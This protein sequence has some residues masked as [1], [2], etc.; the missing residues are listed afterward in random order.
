MAE[1]FDDG[2]VLDELLGVRVGELDRTAPA[3][4]VLRRSDGGPDLGVDGVAAV[5]GQARDS[6]DVYV[7]EDTGLV[8]EEGLN[9]ARGV[10][11]GWGFVRESV[12]GISGDRR[13]HV[14]DD[15]VETDGLVGDGDPVAA[16]SVRSCADF[17]EADVAGILS[18][19]N[20]AA[21]SAGAGLTVSAGAG[22][23][24]VSTGT[25]TKGDTLTIEPRREG[26]FEHCVKYFTYF[27]CG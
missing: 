1:G 24:V 17:D 7:A 14:G 13:V 5:R 8:E 18:L 20:A 22:L 11:R 21:S 16:S 10:E 3:E 9:A 26:I 25:G 23:T 27:A 6:V 19:A 12:K 4:E 2:V 15:L